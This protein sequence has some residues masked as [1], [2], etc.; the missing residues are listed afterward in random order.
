[1]EPEISN[2]SLALVIG[3][4]I[5]LS[6]TG[7]PAAG[8]LSDTDISKRLVGS[9]IVPSDSSDYRPDNRYSV[10]T[11]GADGTDVA[12]WYSDSTCKK[13]T[14]KVTGTWMI[15]GGALISV[16]PNGAKFHDKIASIEGD[17]LTFSD[18]GTT[19]TREKGTFCVTPVS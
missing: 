6:A 1:M 13:I 15:Q 11:Y 3:F 14:F 12:V 17:K 4:G 10:E 9:W 7:A 8:V 5:A 2:N 19:H 18:N 16:L